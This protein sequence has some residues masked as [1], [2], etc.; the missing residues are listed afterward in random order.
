MNLIVKKLDESVV[1]NNKNHILYVQTEDGIN[2]KAEICTEEEVSS[3]IY[4]LK[5]DYDIKQV[6][7]FDL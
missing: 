2:V 7:F 1:N 4:I 5:S 3:Y 6:I